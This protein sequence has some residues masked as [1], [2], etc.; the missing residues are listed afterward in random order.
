M[1]NRFQRFG[2]LLTLALGLAASACSSNAAHTTGKR[3]RLATRFVPSADVSEAFTTSTGWNVQLE[4]ASLAIGGLYYFDGRPAFARLERG[5]LQ[6]LKQVFI[7]TAHAHPQHY[8]AGN[9]LG[10]MVETTSVDLFEAAD[11]PDGSGVTGT[12]RSG[13]LKLPDEPDDIGGPAAAA[14]G[15]HVAA[16]QGVA[17][18]DDRTVHFQIATAL[19]DIQHTSPRAEIDGCVFEEAEVTADGTVTLTVTP[20]VW[21]NL[22]DFADTEAGSGA[23][24]TP[25]GADQTAHRA[26]A[27]G[28]AQ[29]SAYH[30][31][32]TP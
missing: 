24:P 9:A 26:F 6:R 17:R 2:L 12:F 1:T 15:T 31:G 30:F 8:V 23:D 29:L 18:R 28:V 25:I 22:V 21:F 20:R 3:I 13:R 16:A 14:L 19:A 10:E 7:G 32:Y 27:L 4:S 11:L 5:P